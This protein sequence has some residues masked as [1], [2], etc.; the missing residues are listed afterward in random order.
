[1]RGEVPAAD[2]GRRVVLSAD[3]REMT[4]LTQTPAGVHR[5]VFSRGPEQEPLTDTDVE[6][7]LGAVLPTLSE[8]GQRNTTRRWVT[9]FGTVYA[10]LMLG[11][12]T[13]WWPKVRL[14]GGPMVGW[15]RAAVAVGF[16]R[17]VRRG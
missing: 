17:E 12:P 5:A 3:R 15:L 7:A 13:W 6:Y 8:L 1:M 11:P 14:R 4:I 16:R 10:H 9:R 2:D